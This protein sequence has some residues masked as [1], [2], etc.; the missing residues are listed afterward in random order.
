MAKSKK[1]ASKG[2]DLVAVEPATAEVE[3]LPPVTGAVGNF[4]NDTTNMFKARGMRMRGLLG[5]IDQSGQ[6]TEALLRVA[7]DCMEA[8]EAKLDR[9]LRKEGLLP[10]VE[11]DEDE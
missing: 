11:D 5:R 6:R 9:D 8:A 1:G 4:L 3:V 10:E 7:A 2:A